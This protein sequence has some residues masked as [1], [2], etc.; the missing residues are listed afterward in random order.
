MQAKIRPAAPSRVQGNTL[1]AIASQEGWWEILNQPPLEGLSSIVYRMQ[2]LSL[3][4]GDG[5][6]TKDLVALDLVERL[7]SL[8]A[9]ISGETTLSH[10]LTHSSTKAAK[11][12]RRAK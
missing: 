12:A 3:G 8:A 6:F 2:A 9:E 11:V 7:H 1:A 10:G 4:H 5:E